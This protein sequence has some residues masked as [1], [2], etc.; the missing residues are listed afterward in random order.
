[1]GSIYIIA[2]WVSRALIKQGTILLLAVQ[3]ITKN[4]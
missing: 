4:Q 3:G 2:E 1:M